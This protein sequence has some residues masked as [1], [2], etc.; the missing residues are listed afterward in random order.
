MIEKELNKERRKLLAFFI[1]LK[2]AFNTLSREAL[3]KLTRRA[4]IR[5]RPEIYKEINNKIKIGEQRSQ[6]S[7]E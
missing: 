6:R 4:G 7:S 2:T 1:D 3:R 5:S